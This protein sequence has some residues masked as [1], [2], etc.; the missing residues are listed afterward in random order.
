M[1]FLVSL[2]W[3]EGT[4]RTAI[5]T[6]ISCAITMAIMFNTLRRLKRPFLSV[7]A[8]WCLRLQVALDLKA[9]QTSHKM[10]GYI[11][12]HLEIDLRL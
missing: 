3:Y 2:G 10:A 1:C 5:K 11:G 4:I 8:G 6:L 12:G 9:T 7:N